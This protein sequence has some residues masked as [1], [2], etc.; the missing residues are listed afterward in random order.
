MKLTIELVPKTAW[1]SNVR[2]IVSKD[3][4]DLIRKQVYDKAYSLC[5]ICGGVGPK[6][7]VEAHEI[8]SYEKDSG[9]QRLEEILALCPDCHQVKHIGLAEVNGKMEEALVHFM[10]V[11]EMNRKDSIKYINHQFELWAKRSKLKWALNISELSNY[12]ID[13][14][15]LTLKKK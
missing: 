5:Q 11:N 8:W 14:T 12:G 15:K 6:H 2:S 10:K 7:P 1:Y 13:I 3:Q 9:E 4:W